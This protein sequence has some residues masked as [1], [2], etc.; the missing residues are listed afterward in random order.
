MLPAVASELEAGN[1]LEV[2]LRLKRLQRR[3]R[4]ILRTEEHLV[5]GILSAVSLSFHRH[6]I[7]LSSKLYL[8]SKM[9]QMLAQKW[10]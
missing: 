7:R 8:V 5:H 10:V 1:L 4:S 6:V 3:V 2:R 9:E